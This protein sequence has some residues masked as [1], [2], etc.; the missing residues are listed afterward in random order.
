M[1]SSH[2][3]YNVLPA[4]SSQ[5][6]FSIRLPQNSFPFGS[7]RTR[8]SL[9]PSSSS[10]VF[11]LWVFLSCRLDCWLL[12]RRRHWAFH[13]GV[14]SHSTLSTPAPAPDAAP[15]SPKMFLITKSQCVC[16]YWQD[17]GS[18][19]LKNLPCVPSPWLSC[20]PFTRY[21]HT[22]KYGFSCSPVL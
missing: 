11:H 17:E 19:H 4:I 10:R 22:C 2:S 13:S 6:T 3:F 20:P 21:Q 14:S 16:W 9:R 5:P 8:S 15:L 7:Q 18:A 1:T 12:S